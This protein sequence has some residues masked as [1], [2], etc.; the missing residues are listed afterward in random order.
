MR[1]Q[2]PG[3]NMSAVPIVIPFYKAHDK[4]RKCLAAI[5]A[6]S[7]K[8]CE[9]FVRDNT[10]DNILYTTAV[11]VGL[12][13]FC[14]RPE[15]HYVMV[16]N[17]DANMHPQCVRQLVDF[18]DAHP[19]CGVACPLQFAGSGGAMSWSGAANAL[20]VTGGKVVTWGGSLQ[21]FPSGAHRCDPF[22]SY[23]EP[24]ETYWGNGACMMI[25]TQTIREAGLFDKNMRFICSDADF[26]FTARARGWKVFVV[27]DALAEHSLG[28]SGTASSPEI[29]LV[30]CRDA[31][32][33]AQKWLSGD[34]YRQLSFEGAGLTGGGVRQELLKLKRAVQIVERRLG[35]Q[36]AAGSEAF[37]SWVTEMRMA[38]QA[39]GAG[40]F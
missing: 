9:A 15:I 1:W 26:S 36:P 30:K 24:F 27:P 14:Y 2:E 25:R 17:Q 23:T 29:E 40:R 18:M 31:V 12:S 20:T 10:H 5:E 6:Q 19:D 21:A 34:L 7:Y 22:A 37:P 16:L 28:A 38:P 35:A 8:H 13:K 33:F 3:E 4:L 32:Y 39:R 11:N